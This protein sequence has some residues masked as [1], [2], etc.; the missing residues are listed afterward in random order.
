MGLCPG[1][2]SAVGAQCGLCASA[3]GLR[4]GE[5]TAGTELGATRPPQAALRHLCRSPHPTPPPR[6]PAAGRASPAA[7][8]AHTRGTARPVPQSGARRGGVVPREDGPRRNPSSAT[9]APAEHPPPNPTPQLPHPARLSIPAPVLRAWWLSSARLGRRSPTAGPGEPR[10]LCGRSEPGA[11]PRSLPSAARAVAAP[12]RARGRGLTEAGTRVR[13]G[14]QRRSSARPSRQA[15]PSPCVLGGPV[16]KET[17]S[18]SV[19][20]TKATW[21]RRGARR[22]APWPVARG[23]LEGATDAAPRPSP[24][25]APRSLAPPKRGAGV[26]GSSRRP[27]RLVSQTRLFKQR[28]CVRARSGRGG[29]C[30][31]GPPSSRALL[32]P[33]GW[34]GPKRGH[35]PGPLCRHHLSTHSSRRQGRPRGQRRQPRGQQG[36]APRGSR[37]P[38]TAGPSEE[39]ALGLGGWRVAQ[40]PSRVPWGSLV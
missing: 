15:Q 29:R 10:R 40:E 3:L 11:P 18:E 34:V 21:G 6:P 20:D 14:G 39:G 8:P 16:G 25:A 2:W 9:P 4:A 22:V 13:L 36:C 31:A 35:S 1:G 26:T 7:F 37:A 24:P 33:G 19:R 38:G 5:E 30:R 12:E 32:T 28:S 17:L 27:R 23:H